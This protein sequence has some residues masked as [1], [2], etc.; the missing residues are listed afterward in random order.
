M[1]WS[2]VSKIYEVIEFDQKPCFAKFC[3]GVTEARHQG[4]GDSTLDVKAK[5]S[6]L[7]GNCAFGSMIQNHQEIKYVRGRAQACKRVEDPLFKHLTEVG[8]DTYEIYLYT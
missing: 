3:E 7:L 2:K 8:Q 4:D 6:K 1:D 5:T